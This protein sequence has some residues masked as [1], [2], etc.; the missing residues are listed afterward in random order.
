MSHPI[1]RHSI[2]RL[3][4]VKFDGEYRV[5]GCIPSDDNH[6]FPNFG[7]QL[8]GQAQNE[9]R[10]IDLAPTYNNRILNQGSTSA[11]VGHG[12]ASGMEL[13]WKQLGNPP[14]EFTP[15]F[16]YGLINGGRDAGA[17][18]SNGLM[19]LKRYGAALN[20]SLPA[21]VM[22][23]NQFP[24]EAMTQAMRF[25]L[26]MAFKCGNFDEIC[27]A[28]N[29]GFAAPVGLMVGDN[30]SMVDAN[31]VCPLRTSG[32]GGH[33][34]LGVGLKKHPSYG[35][36]LKIQNSW[37]ERFGNKG[38]AYLRREHF[39]QMAPDAFAIQAAFDDPQDTKP[40]DNV[41]VVTG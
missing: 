3:P 35:W 34:V 32:G 24:Q 13:V 19:A 22:F 8:F 30:F 7:E 21:G 15:F 16:I 33:C 5:L 1:G 26:S 37:G 23:Q 14:Q 6:D 25:R 29:L 11:C 2:S 27:Q 17:M 39:S 20:G 12:C 9:L 41:P 36:L 40:D 18:I 4:S 31:G 38:H 10:E 28:V